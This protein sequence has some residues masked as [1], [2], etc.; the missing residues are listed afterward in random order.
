MIGVLVV[1]HGEMAKGTMN[2]CDMVLGNHNN[3]DFVSLT[4]GVESFANNLYS[5]LNEMMEK[6]EEIIIISDLK[7]GTPYNQSLKYKLEI[8]KDKVQ[9]LCGFNLPMFAEL[10]TMLPYADSAVTLAKQIVNTAKDSIEI[11]EEVEL[12]SDDD[13]FD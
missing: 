11:Y 2:T 10:L 12:S 4:E 5:K 9:L 8:G 6:Y 13:M 1:S 3:C 7:G